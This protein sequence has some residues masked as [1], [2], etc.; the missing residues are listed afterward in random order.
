MSNLD[1][2]FILILL[3]APASDAGQE[4]DY[5]G[6]EWVVARDIWDR[7]Q[8]VR[9]QNECHWKDHPECIRP[10]SSHG[11]QRRLAIRQPQC[12]TTVYYADREPKSDTVDLV[13]QLSYDFDDGCAEVECLLNGELA[14]LSKI[15][16]FG[17]VTVV[18]PFATPI[19][20]HDGLQWKCTAFDLDNDG[21]RV[22]VVTAE[23]KFDLVALETPTDNHRK[24][25]SYRQSCD[26]SQVI[27]LQ[28]ESMA[29]NAWHTYELYR[30]ALSAC[31]WG[32]LVRNARAREGALGRLMKTSCGTATSELHARLVGFQRWLRFK[33]VS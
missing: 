13:L 26:S 18:V 33:E 12:G 1:F 19:R 5:I 22:N 6:R 14:S 4:V 32:G 29:V 8:A 11:V 24:P 28:E 16:T 23:S 25:L 20:S 17:S 30:Q 27:E 7:G 2:L 3:L 15:C 21:A 10:R 9:M 31:L